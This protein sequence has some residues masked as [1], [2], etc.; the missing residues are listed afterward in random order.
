MKAEKAA[1][2]N[3]SV[4]SVISSSQEQAGWEAA[5]EKSILAQEL[6]GRELLRF[7]V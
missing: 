3:S 5:W 6:V 1:H 7:E 2:N 4:E